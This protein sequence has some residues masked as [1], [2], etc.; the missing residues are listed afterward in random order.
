MNDPDAG[1]TFIT[2]VYANS[3][4]NKFKILTFGRKLDL[5]IYE[6][7][8]L[9]LS[10]LMIVCMQYHILF[11]EKVKKNNSKCLL[12]KYSSYKLNLLD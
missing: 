3:A 7:N 2:L 10:T 12:L 5:T 8:L 9:K 4:Y 1:L 11:S 6:N